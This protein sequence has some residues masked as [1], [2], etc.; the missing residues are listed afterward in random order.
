MLRVE[1]IFDFFVG[2]GGRIRGRLHGSLRIHFT[3]PGA[4]Q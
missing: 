4:S 1:S 3:I 2:A